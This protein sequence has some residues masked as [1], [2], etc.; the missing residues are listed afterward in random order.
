MVPPSL[1]AQPGARGHPLGGGKGHMEPQRLRSLSWSSSPEPF[2]PQKRG[3]RTLALYH[4]RAGVVGSPGKDRSGRRP[5]CGSRCQ[6][7]G[8]EAEACDLC[9]GSW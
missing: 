3:T 2:A 6:P 7:V 9:W 4:L 5:A 1:A 8:Q